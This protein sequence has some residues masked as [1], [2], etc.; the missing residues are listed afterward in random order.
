[1]FGAHWLAQSPWLPAILWLANYERAAGVSVARCIRVGVWL[2]LARSVAVGVCAALARSC[3][4]GG[5][6]RLARLR[7]LVVWKAMTR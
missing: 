2:D 4:L 7:S 3:T 5:W 6:P 1:M